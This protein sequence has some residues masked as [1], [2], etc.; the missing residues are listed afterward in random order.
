MEIAKIVIVVLIA[1]VGL[2]S[3]VGK[4]RKK[5]AVKRPEKAASSAP[6]SA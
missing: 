2:Y 4:R 1:L 3:E 5:E 6:V